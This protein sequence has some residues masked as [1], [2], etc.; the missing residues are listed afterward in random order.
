ME[1]R[2]A[3]RILVDVPEHYDLV[4][5]VEASPF[6][7]L[8]PLVF[9]GRQRALQAVLYAP[10]G[11]AIEVLVHQ[12]EPGLPLLVAGFNADRDAEV[13]LGQLRS[14]LGLD[15]DLAVFYAFCDH[16]KSLSWV[17]ARDAGRALRSPTVFEDLV[18][19]LLVSRAAHPRVAAM[20]LHLCQELGARTN[21]ARAAFPSATAIA[22]ASGSLFEQN[23]I[24]R[25]CA[26][27]LC[28]L[29]VRCADGSFY[30]ESLR[31][32]PRR[33]S[34]LVHDEELFGDVI[35]EEL[36]WQFRISRLL[37]GLPGFGPRARDLMLPLLGC[38]EFLALDMATLRAWQRR[39][40]SARRQPALRH[41]E[42]SWERLI[43][44][45]ERRVAPY[46]LYGGLAERLL[47]RS[48]EVW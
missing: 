20:M 1:R 2:P 38:Y 45:I 21:L 18:K 9:D 44:T 26:E 10:G 29:A 8:P 34:E 42:L 12:I 14:V 31:R 11:A 43:R 35:E 36:E 23:P 24:F 28:A 7:V 37:A 32:P 3:E 17:R 6:K 5:L 19:C 30:P 47:L 48:E 25:T 33:F 41:R 4:G 22:A 39:F 13:L 40:P 46:S 27:P 15:E 16:D